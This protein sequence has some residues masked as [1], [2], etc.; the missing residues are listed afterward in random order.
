MT[1]VSDV[2]TIESK[3]S[4]ERLQRQQHS[5]WTIRKRVKDSRKEWTGKR[6]AQTRMSPILMKQDTTQHDTSPSKFNLLS[7]EGRKV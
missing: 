3:I 5:T 2:N 7:Q 4:T 1:F 6:P